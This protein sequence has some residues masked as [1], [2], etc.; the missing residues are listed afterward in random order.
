MPS[1]IVY[2]IDNARRVRLGERFDCAADEPAVER[3]GRIDREG[4]EAELWQGGRLI[5]RLSAKGELSKGSN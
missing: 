3:F 2:L 4:G 1:Y 5:A